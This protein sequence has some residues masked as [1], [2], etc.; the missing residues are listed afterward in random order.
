M[1]VDYR[2][3]PRFVGADVVRIAGASSVQGSHPQMCVR[4]RE[5][6]NIEKKRKL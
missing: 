2:S 1:M 3:R 4:D 6:R 5:E